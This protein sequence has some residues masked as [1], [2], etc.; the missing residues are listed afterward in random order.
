LKL[1][2]ASWRWTE[3]RRARSSIAIAILLCGCAKP[4]ELCI[5]VVLGDEGVKAA[6]LA[7]EDLN[8]AGGVPIT[9]RSLSGAYGSSAQVALQGA[10]SLATDARVLAVVGHTNSSASLSASQVYNARHVVQL[11][12]TSTAP[13][14][15][16]AGPYSFRMVGSDAHQARFLV[17]RLSATD[18]QR[19]ALVYANDD[20]GRSLRQLTVDALAARD[21]RPVFQ[22]PYAETETDGTDI[23]RALVAARPTV[24]VWLGRFPYYA[25]V[26][27]MLRAALPSLRVLAS[28][29]F[30]GSPMGA[31]DGELEE[32]QYVRLV[33]VDTSS[34]RIRTLA[35]RF[36]SMKGTT[37]LSDQA[38][39]AYDAVMLLGSGLREVGAD[40]EALRRWLERLGRERPAYVGITGPIL[41]SPEG[42]RD[43]TYALVRAS[44][45]LHHT[46]H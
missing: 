1:W 5:G 17:S 33:T 14:Y 27:P 44:D 29:G 36:A 3:G 15:S 31:R 16:Q 30:G 13:L 37:T 12:P 25:R 24:L 9:L 32:V 23:A 43:P 41:F 40:R 35:R 11:A 18:V 19:V 21:V 39:L 38:V 28:D 20:Y 46:G 2:T 4:E 26:R 22:G 10:E 42:D 6:Q 45:R 7:V 8:A 34:A